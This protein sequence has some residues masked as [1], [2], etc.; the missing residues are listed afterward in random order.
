MDIYHHITPLTDIPCI[1]ISK[2]KPV[3]SL[4]NSLSDLIY[5]KSIV[6]SLKYVQ[7]S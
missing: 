4:W 6:L 7:C 2:M 3:F 1:Q 5:S